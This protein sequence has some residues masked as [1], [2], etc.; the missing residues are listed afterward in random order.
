MNTQPVITEQ[1]LF[2]EDS[3]SWL[4]NEE[5]FALI[6]TFSIPSGKALFS[7]DKP[8]FADMPPKDADSVQQIKKKPDIKTPSSASQDGIVPAKFDVL[9]ERDKVSHSHVGNKRF[10]H[11]IKMNQVRYQNA[12]SREAKTRITE[13]II[14][15]IRSR[16]GRFL[17]F[18]ADSNEWTDVGDEKAHEKVSHALRSVKGP[19]KPAGTSKPTSNKP[20]IGKEP[21]QSIA[22][23]QPCFLFFF[24]WCL[25]LLYLSMTTNQQT[26]L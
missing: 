20:C 7:G 13:D 22:P 6:R 8:P 21:S 24:W 17:K 4:F 5:D 11:I 1:R 16:G 3:S 14:D 10:R 23:L 15:I 18:D 12:T 2:S 26:R 19:T 9:Y 25:F